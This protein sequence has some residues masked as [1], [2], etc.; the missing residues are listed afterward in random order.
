MSV[1]TEGAGASAPML[2]P[3]LLDT[4]R[5]SVDVAFV[6][7]LHAEDV[8]RPRLVSDDGK[9]DPAA[10]DREQHAVHGY[11]WLMTYA[12]ALRALA[13]W[14]ENLERAGQFGERE[15]LILQLGF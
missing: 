9:I 13:D 3:Y 10:L 11:A 7:G 15:Q 14:A 6:V 4:C 2:M 12:V 5:D 1:A 8:L